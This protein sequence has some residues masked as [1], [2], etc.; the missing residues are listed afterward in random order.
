MSS[1]ILDALVL[2]ILLL[3]VFRGAKRGLIL[4]LF[5]LSTVFLAFFGARMM[6]GTL[7]AP[8]ADLIQPSIQQTLE[9]VLPLPGGA[10]EVAPSLPEEEPGLQDIVAILRENEL[11]SG[12]QELL[13]EAVQNQSIPI[14]TT[15]VAAAARYLAELAAYALVYALSFAGI[16]LLCFLLGHTLDFAFR[17]PVLSQFNCLGGALIGLVKGFLLASILLW[18]L[19]LGGILTPDNTGPVVALMNLQ[20]LSGLIQPLLGTL[21]AVFSP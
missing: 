16:L 20:V 14:V 13:A 7:S 5:G 12:L 3:A 8:I 19:R 6:A 11:F 17:L 18:L 2:A 10:E 1:Y 4:T 15:A 21:A 9:E